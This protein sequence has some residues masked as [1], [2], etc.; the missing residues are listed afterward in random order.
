MINPLEADEAARNEGSSPKQ[1]SSTRNVVALVT[2]VAR[3]R[4]ERVNA[5]A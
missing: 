1:P 5:L 4:A 3:K 2:K